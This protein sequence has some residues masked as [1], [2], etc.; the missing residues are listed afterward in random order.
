MITVATCTVAY[1]QDAFESLKPRSHHMN[2][3]E[4]DFWTLQ[5][6]GN[7]H[8]ARTWV[9]ELCDLVRCVCSQSVRSRVT[10]DCAHDQLT[11]G[12]NG[13][14]SRGRSIQFVRCDRGVSFNRRYGVCWL[15]SW[16][17]LKLARYTKGGFTADELNWTEVI[18]NKL[19]QLHDALLVT[20]VSVTK[21][22][23]CCSRTGVQFSS[24][25]LLRTRPLQIQC[26]RSYITRS[27]I[28][29]TRHT[30][31]WSAIASWFH[32]ACLCICQCADQSSRGRVKI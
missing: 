14:T 17:R 3:T 25:H 21:L 7:I 19:T 32:T 26:S 22:I 13:P 23:G 8:I 27:C 6:N 29:S 15:T 11:L 30:L 2:W 28:F 10:L 16:Y 18:C 20:R 31:L 1:T 12:V 24:V 4:R 9:H 5:T